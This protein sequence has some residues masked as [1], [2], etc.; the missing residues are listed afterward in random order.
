M[1]DLLLAITIFSI[2]FS[3]GLSIKKEDFSTIFQNKKALVFGLS[4]QIIGLPLLAFL[5]IPF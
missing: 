2:L 4:A 3:I 5:L 1:V